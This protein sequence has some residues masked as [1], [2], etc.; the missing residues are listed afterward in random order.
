[1][2]DHLLSSRRVVTHIRHCS[3]LARRGLPFLS[4]RAPRYFVVHVR[5][6]VRDSFQCV[7]KD[8][9]VSAADSGQHMKPLQR[10]LLRTWQELVG[11]VGFST[12]RT[13]CPPPVRKRCPRP[14]V[15][16][17]VVA[18]AR[19]PITACG[20][21]NALTTVATIMLHL[22]EEIPTRKPAHT[23]LKRVHRERRTTLTQTA[24]TAQ[25]TAATICSRWVSVFCRCVRMCVLCDR[26]LAH[27]FVCD[28]AVVLPGSQ[29]TSGIGT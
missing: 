14:C 7:V 15:R 2:S 3:N 23:E 18:S 1:M 10:H 12:L 13:Y 22:N 19:L 24:Q 25:T 9:R 21:G 4:H 27:C 20:R 5:Y 16:K 8:L 28:G 17:Q 26:C 11:D 6:L 29:T